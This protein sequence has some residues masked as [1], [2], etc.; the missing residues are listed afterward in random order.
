MS[1]EVRSV[2]RALQILRVMNERVS[3]TLQ[4]LHQRTG[5]A[6][7]TLH[8]LLSTLETEKYV[9]TDPHVYG[10]YQLTQA[11]GN[12]SCGITTQMQLAELAAPIMVSTTHAIKWPLSLGVIDRH[13][14]RI[15]YCT[16][17]YSPYAMRPSSIG[18][19]YELTE[20]A[21]GRAYLSFCGPDER[22][23][24]I[25][26][27][28]S[29]EDDGPRLTDLRAMRH[30]IRETRKQGFAVRYGQHRSESAA[31]AVP[32]FSAGML[33]GVLVYTTFARQMDDRMLKRAVP[34]VQGTAQRIGEA[35]AP[36]LRAGGSPSAGYASSAAPSAPRA[37]PVSRVA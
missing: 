28:N 16:M 20:S 11:V 25:E 18:K 13:Q 35:L 30:M 6:K 17:P 26:E 22:R 29:R 23:I 32:V 4:E 8:R 9:R 7:S 33:R 27:M 2:Q 12:L 34:T 24:L 31:L 14:I 15:V 1:T 19:R 10:H 21:S 37:E 36:A 5:L 3:W